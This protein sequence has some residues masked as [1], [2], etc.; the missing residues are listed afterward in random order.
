MLN[1]RKFAAIDLAFLGSRVILTEFSVGVAGSTI[2]GIL[3]LRAGSHRFH[4]AR[5]IVLGAYLLSLGINYVPLL[6]NAIDLARRGHAGL[7]IA[8]ELGDKRAAFRKYRRQSLLLLI[9]L[10][11]AVAAIVQEVRRRHSVANS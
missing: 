1:V 6:L 2:L 11:V 4:S 7:E 9:P 3:T 10:L 8:D 5:M